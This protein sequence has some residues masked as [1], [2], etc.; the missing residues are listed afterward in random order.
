MSNK[1]FCNLFIK[2]RA[3]AEFISVFLIVFIGCGSIRVLS[4]WP[5]LFPPS[6]IP[7]I[8]MVSVMAGIFFFGRYSGG[9]LNPSVTFSIACM[10]WIPWKEARNYILAQFSGGFIASLLHYIILPGSSSFGG[11]I[12]LVSPWRACFSEA[13]IMCIFLYGIVLFFNKFEKKWH[14]PFF[15]IWFILMVKCAGNYGTGLSLNP[16]RSLGPNIFEGQIKVIWI[17]FIGPTLGSLAAFYLF[18]NTDIIYSMFFK[19][20]NAPSFRKRFK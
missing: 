14:L 8:F 19:K 1:L 17:Y 4:L 20:L 7:N 13:I 9:H 16:A 11:T 10:G 3:F 12:P 2:N 18:K 6:W 15:L 5:G